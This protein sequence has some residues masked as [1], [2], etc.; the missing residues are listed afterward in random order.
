[1][2]VKNEG[3]ISIKNAGS[4]AKNNETRKGNINE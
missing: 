3:S 1:M 4:I 2:F